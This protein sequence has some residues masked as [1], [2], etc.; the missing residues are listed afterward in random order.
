MTNEELAS[1]ITRLVQNER[2]TWTTAPAPK[3]PPP[4]GGTLTAYVGNAPKINLIATYW[5]EHERN[6][7][8]AMATVSTSTGIL[9]VSLNPEQAEICFNAAK[10]KH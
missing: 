9:I 3:E 5:T 8:S 7:Y 2:V 4:P 10:S 1:E 6:G